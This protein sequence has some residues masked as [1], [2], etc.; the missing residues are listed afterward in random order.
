MCGE[1][2][3]LQL[4]LFFGIFLFLTAC[5]VVPPEQ[6]I[7]YSEIRNQ[8]LYDLLQ[9]HLLGRIAMANDKDSW[10]AKID[11][12]H[13]VDKDV[14]NLS[15]PLGQGAVRIVLYPDSIMIDQGDGQVG[16]SKNVDQYIKQ[17]LGFFVPLVALRFWVIGLNEPGKPFVSFDDGFS[18]FSWN[19]KYHNY[20]QVGD[21]WMPRKISIKN[22]SAKLKLMIDQWT[23]NDY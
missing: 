4:A 19:I 21:G 5:A 2:K 18:Q 7:K 11:W 12:L 8:Q 22:N 15:G 1:Y 6:E 10:S 17:Q 16:F 20:I 13:Q 23:I 9:W 3:K 14:L